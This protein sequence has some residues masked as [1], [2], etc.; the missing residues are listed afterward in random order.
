MLY[1]A[2]GSLMDLAQLR[3][4]CPHAQLRHRSA[5]LDGYEL[6][7]RRLSPMR[8]RGGVAD[9]VP[10]TNASLF[11]C[12]WELSEAELA[13]LD[14]REGVAVGAYRRLAV[15]VTTDGRGI[16]AETYTV[17]EKSPAPIPPTADYGRLMLDNAR[18][19]GL[20]HNYQAQMQSLLEELGVVL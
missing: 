17:V 3:E 5:R 9:I 2:Y 15:T 8:W 20:P 14:R 11:G 10:R 6:D 4:S 19:L 12:I 1:F 18:E 13:A 7:F 16:E